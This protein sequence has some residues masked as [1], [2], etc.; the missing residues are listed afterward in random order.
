MIPIFIDGPAV[1][2]ITLA[3]MK[4]YLRADDDPA[5]D[6]LIAGLVKA[7]RLTIEAA[8]RRILIAQRW[9]VVLDRW[10]PGGTILLPLSPVIAIDSIRVTD[11]AGVASDVP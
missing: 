11:A 9:R 2:P 6:D 8:S 7:A 4:A 5:Q 10:P 3:E 1:E